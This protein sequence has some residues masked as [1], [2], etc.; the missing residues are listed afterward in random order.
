MENKWL[1]E[2]FRK[3]ERGQK[4]RERENRKIVILSIIIE[5][6]GKMK[7]WPKG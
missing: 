2:C 1:R 7:S 5:K 6:R 3:R 4:I